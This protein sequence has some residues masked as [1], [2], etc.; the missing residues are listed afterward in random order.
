MAIDQS[1][2]LHKSPTS[3]VK[4]F[5]FQCKTD[6]L[7]TNL[8]VMT[9]G[10]QGVY[11]TEVVP[12]GAADKAGVQVKDHLLE[13]NGESVEKSSHDQIVEKIKQGGNSIMFL[14]ADEETKTFY[15]NKHAKM[16]SWLAIVKNLPLQPRII[17]LTKGSDG[18]GFMLREEPNQT[19]RVMI[20]YYT[21]RLFRDII[22]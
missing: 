2:D 11:M 13:V 7:S 19:G 20:F 22:Y 3:S 15:Q 16:G 10:E 4:L 14:L 21:F 9:T 12:G 17:K 1:I 6:I 8:D 5:T 18:Y